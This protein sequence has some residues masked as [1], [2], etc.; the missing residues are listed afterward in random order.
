MK[1]KIVFFDA[2]ETL[3]Y[4]NPSLTELSFRFFRKNGININRKKLTAAF[5]SAA[6]EMKPVVRQARMNDL[7]KWRVYIRRVFRK[8]GVRD[9]RLAENLKDKLKCGSSFR[10]H[11]DALSTVK[12]FRR[13]NIKTGIISNAPKE[14]KE[15]L[16]RTGLYRHFK[17]VII[18]EI[19]GYEKP[20][21][22]IFFKALKTAGV[23]AKDAVYV[24]DNY[25][26]DVEGAKKAG[27]S[28]VWLVRKAKNSE[29]SFASQVKD[30]KTPRIKNLK[31]LIKTAEKE[32]W[33]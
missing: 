29:F 24:G 23:K 10:P 8:L 27:I 25:I 3:I 18:S 17:P 28:P 5:N 33:I 26:A 19:A 30:R 14:L 21:K 12:V 22:R 2:G 6:L 9:T 11:S 1:K 31:S 13:K 20:D 7:Q 16:V 15:I 32:G 4:R